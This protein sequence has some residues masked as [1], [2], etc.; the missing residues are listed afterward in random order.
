MLNINRVD[1]RGN[2]SSSK[3]RGT[4]IT[5]QRNRGATVTL[6]VNIYDTMSSHTGR[7]QFWSRLLSSLQCGAPYTPFH[8][9]SWRQSARLTEMSE[10][11][12]GVTWQAFIAGATPSGVRLHRG[13]AEKKRWRDM[14]PQVSTSLADK[15]NLSL[16]PL[17]LEV[18]MEPPQSSCG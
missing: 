15:S 7:Q 5:N 2:P 3:H 6:H 13:E 4:G 9:L 1:T 14:E 18:A 17:T 12:I 10:D 11:G 16:R 8:P